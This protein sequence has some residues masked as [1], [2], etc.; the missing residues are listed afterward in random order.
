VVPTR[1]RPAAL[2]RCLRALASQG[3]LETIVVDD[4]SARPDLVEAAAREAG[5]RLLR[6]DGRG[7]AAARNLGAAE[8]R[9]RVICFI[10]DDCEPRAG[11][12]ARLAQA[13]L[14]GTPAAGVTLNA[15]PES[16]VASASQA[17]TNSLMTASLDR[18]TGRLGFAPSCNLA[19]P[20][21]L[22]PE[23]PFDE[24]FPSAAG[25][26]RE[27]S[28]RAQRA[29]LAPVLVPD[30]VVGHHQRMRVAD[31][32][33]QQLGYGRGAHRFRRAHPRDGA[34]PPRQRVYRRLIS[35][36]REQGPAV[37]AWVLAAQ[38]LIAAGFAAEGVS[39]LKQGLSRQA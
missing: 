20:S 11:W 33:R 24:S 4:R 12:A 8:A 30:A 15:A 7:A 34:D 25:E 23:L 38:A 1:D 6:G 17:I 3:V 10:D 36:V 2:H 9:G 21:S 35:A 32:A 29:G 16:A 13:A 39:A 14:A 22:A 37:G 26:D 18:S 28:T 27:W 31:F 19:V 5:A